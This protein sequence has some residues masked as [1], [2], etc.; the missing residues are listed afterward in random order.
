MNQKTLSLNFKSSR[1]QMFFKIGVL[2]N[3]AIF[4]GKHLCW[5]YFLIKL[6]AWR[7]AILLKRDSNT[8]VFL[9]ILQNFK[10]HLFRRTSAK[11]CFC[12]SN[13]KV[14]NKYWASFLN[15]KHDV[16]WFLLKRFVDLVRLYSLLI[17]SR[18]HSKTLLLLGL[19]KNRS[20]VKNRSSDVTILTGLD[21]LLSTT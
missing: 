16:G 21:R 14:S 9:G 13:N 5:S 6:Q 3:F 7:F 2:K 17:I 4:A 1:S 19:Q 8:G 10:E 15:Q 20:K 11:G 12:T 18:N